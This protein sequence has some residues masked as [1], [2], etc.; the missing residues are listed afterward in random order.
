MDT[1]NLTDSLRKLGSQA[2]EWIQ[3]VAATERDRRALSYAGIGAGVILLY[4]IFQFFSSGS[5][6][7]ERKAQTLQAELKKLDTLRSE[8]IQSKRSIED[9]SKKIKTGNESLISLVE[10]TLVESQIDRGNFSI[11]SRT[12][13][14]GDLYEETSVDVEVKKI[15]LSK[16]V[17]VL[18]KIQTMPIFLKVSKFR[19]QTRFDNADFMD[20]SFRVSTFKLNEVL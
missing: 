4:L 15:P 6:R 18:Y 13:T 14:S 19:P 8:Y 1:N 9:V 12:P 16:M 20:A 7:L 3:R 17:D 5:A 11:K 2:R 10:K